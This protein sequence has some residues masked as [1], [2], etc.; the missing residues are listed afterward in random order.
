MEALKKFEP[1][2]IERAHTLRPSTKG[3]AEFQKF[4]LAIAASEQKQALE[5]CTVASLIQCGLEAIANGFSFTST[6][7][8][9]Y[10]IPY[11][12]VAK[13]MPT[14]YGFKKLALQ[15]GALKHVGEPTPVF[16]GEKFSTTVE[17]FNT[18]FSHETN[19]DAER[20]VAKLKGAYVP[21]ERRNGSVGCFYMSK[22]QLDDLK[23]M[24]KGSKAWDT[25]GM[26]LYKTLKHA[27]KSFMPDVR[28]V[29]ASFAT[30]EEAQ[31]SAEYIEAEE[32]KTVDISDIEGLS[33]EGTQE[34]Q[35]EDGFKLF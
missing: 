19:F 24:S 17:G 6:S 10:L 22:S 23:K 31:Q 35:E 7:P 28:I 26:Y 13:I 9:V 8:E 20:S 34:S 15:S 30:E 18:F 21:F 29:G 3:E 2:F 16:E 5:A 11:G 25:L 14:A 1:A 27:L 32:V 12:K 4:M 33:E